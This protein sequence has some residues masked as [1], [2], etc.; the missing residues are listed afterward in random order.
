MT[1]HRTH[2]CKFAAA[3]ALLA[4]LVLAA[5]ARAQVVTSNPGLPVTYP[6][7]VY[8]TPDQVHADFHGPGLA[9][10][11]TNIEHRPFA[12][13]QVHTN[14]PN[15][16][17][18][19]NSEMVGM[20][21]VN[22]GPF[23]PAQGTGPVTTE[24][25]GKAGNTT[26]TF[27]TEMLALNLSGTSPFGPFMIRESPTL[28]STGQTSI[29]DLGGGLYRIDSFFDVFTELSID[30]GNTWMPSDGPAHVVLTPTPEP[31]VCVLAGVAG[32]VALWRVRGIRRQS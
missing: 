2:D 13:A 15:E 6:D 3:A 1:T 12:P 23:Q 20:V 18:D 8:R 11:L 32:L 21:N 9:I 22:G 10:V 5:P 24:V 19:F 30:G 7:G 27:N 14:G 31:S 17:E 26:G 25:F 4:A 29:T 28:A 16:Q